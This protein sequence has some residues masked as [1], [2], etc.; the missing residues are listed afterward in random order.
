M[1]RKTALLICCLFMFGFLF[2][3]YNEIDDSSLTEST[4]EN[5]GINSATLKELNE[6]IPNDYPEIIS[7]II[8]RNGN[9]VFE[10]YYGT[11]K[12][13]LNELR[14]VTK[15]FISALIGIS[16]DK[17][18]LDGVDQK[19]VDFFPE[20]VNS[21]TDPKFKEITIENLLTMRA[22]ID[23]DN[24]DTPKYID[25]RYN[26]NL[27]KP[28]FEDEL[29][30]SP[31]GILLYNDPTAHFLSAIITKVSGM[32]TMDF[33]EKY[34][35]DK[36]DISRYRW[37][38]DY[39]D[40]NLGGSGLNLRTRDSAKFGQLYLNKGKWNGEQVISSEWIEQSTKKYTGGNRVYHDYGYLWWTNTFSSYS[41][42]I[43]S[44]FG[45]QNIF[46]IPDLDMVV[47][48][49]S[50]TNIKEHNNQKIIDKYIIPAV[51]K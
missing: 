21:K 25:W 33:A 44:G 13:S 46:V 2:G 24:H 14:S 10:E 35:F 51:E 29:P 49:N 48:I 38:K 45:G 12:N 39:Q 47:A 9:I 31:G 1:L 40:Y 43:A 42:Y 27:V 23:F 8:L 4:P 20:Y 22:G 41:C 7:T 18:Y 36:L 28:F 34:L 17:G 19:L 11:R 15:S 3:C 30:Y 50:K 16:I 26:R 6:I 32:S 37:E 5:N